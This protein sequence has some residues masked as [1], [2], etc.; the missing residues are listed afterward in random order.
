MWPNSNM[1]KL[2]KT[3]RELILKYESR[4]PDTVPSCEKDLMAE[5]E[6]IFKA[7]KKEIQSWDVE[8][9]DYVRIANAWIANT[10]FDLLASGKY[11]IY[12]GQLNPMKCSSNLM[13]VYSSAMDYGESIGMITK[14]GI[15]EEFKKLHD[16]I[17]HVG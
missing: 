14:E 7:S 2:L 8:D 13:L 11:H 16:A 3:C 1:K 4:N 10:A 5:L 6:K 17:S 9:T 15:E 12:Y